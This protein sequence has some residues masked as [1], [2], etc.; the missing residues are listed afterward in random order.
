MNQQTINVS[1]EDFLRT[2]NFGVIKFGMTSGQ[3]LNLLGE[4]DFVFT[5]SK[6][7][8]PTGFEYGDIEFYFISH[9][10]SR[11]CAIYLDEFDIP[12][13][14]QHLNIDAWKLRSEMPQSEVEEILIQANIKF[15]PTEMP[16]STMNGII[17]EGG[18]ELGFIFYAD[19][20]SA[21]EGLYNISRSLRHEM[22]V[23]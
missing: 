2:G 19:E 18:V 5:H 11:L 16:D 1:F 10:D 15:Q 6:S 9:K 22:D 4:P 8:R 14:S 13:G 7:K 3:I 23:N 12:K 21:P 17:T 20:F